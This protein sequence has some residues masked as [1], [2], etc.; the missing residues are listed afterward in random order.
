MGNIHKY[1][2]NFANNCHSHPKF[3]PGMHLVTSWTSSIMGDLDLILRSQVCFNIGNIL[4]LPSLIAL[5]NCA[6][7]TPTQ[8]YSCLWGG[9]AGMG[10]IPPPTRHPNH[11]SPITPKL[12]KDTMG[13]FWSYFLLTSGYA[14]WAKKR[15]VANFIEVY[16]IVQSTKNKWDDS[17]TITV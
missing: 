15:Q 5:L 9:A 14:S 7:D 16:F 3:V 1:P 6:R 2:R 4:S 10:L 8:V 17:S 11:H 13:P 12:S